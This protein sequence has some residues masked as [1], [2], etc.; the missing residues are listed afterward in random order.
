ECKTPDWEPPES[1]LHARAREFLAREQDP[2]HAREDHLLDPETTY[3]VL[4]RGVQTYPDLR[5]QGR[6]ANGGPDVLM[7]SYRE[8]ARYEVLDGRTVAEHEAA[9]GKIDGE[10]RD[11]YREDLVGIDSPDAEF[12]AHAREDVDELLA[13][14]DRLRDA[15]HILAAAGDAELLA[16]DFDSDDL[17]ERGLLV[18]SRDICDEYYTEVTLKGREFVRAAL[19]RAATDKATAS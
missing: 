19:A 6:K 3:A 5:F 4:T 8:M 10:R 7:H 18:L 11:L 2:L 1:E 9:G 17:F 13:E 12:I 15:L 16:E 14:V